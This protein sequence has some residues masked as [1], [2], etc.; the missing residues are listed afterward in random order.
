MNKRFNAYMHYLMT[1]I[2][3]SNI[4]Y[5]VMIDMLMWMLTLNFKYNELNFHYLTTG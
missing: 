1:N 4:F 3:F 2:L 5:Y